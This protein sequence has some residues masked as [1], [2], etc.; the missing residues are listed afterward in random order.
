MQAA[1]LCLAQHGEWST[2]T[3]GGICFGRWFI[4]RRIRLQVTMQTVHNP[5]IASVCMIFFVRVF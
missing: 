2:K 4:G 5:D 1:G 3:T